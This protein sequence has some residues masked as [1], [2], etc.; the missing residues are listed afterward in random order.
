MAVSFTNA[1]KVNVEETIQNAVKN[2]FTGSVPIF[3][4]PNF[5]FRGNNF[6]T[7]SALDS[8]SNNSMYSVIPNTFNLQLTYYHYD[9]KRN[10]LSVK[11]FFKQISRLEEVFYSLLGVSPSYSFTVQSI[12]YEDDDEMEGFRKAIFNVQVS[13]IR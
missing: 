1:W 13:N 2:E 11:K 3:R 6:M 4:T 7:I 9:S 10:D 8:F 5:K 12:N